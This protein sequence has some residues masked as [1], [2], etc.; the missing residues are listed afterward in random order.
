MNNQPNGVNFAASL[1]LKFGEED[2]I[3]PKYL[4]RKAGR[5]TA[6]HKDLQLG[7]EASR[8]VALVLADAVNHPFL[9]D[10]QVLSVLPE[11]NGQRLCVTVGHY[12]AMPDVTEVEMVEELKRIQGV[13]RCALAQAINRKRMPMLS[14][15]Y[16]GL[17]EQIGQTDP[18]GA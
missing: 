17:I 12:G 8:I 18:G 6:R 14:F 1:C 15:R 7:K 4:A 10:L 16:V 11:H 3:D 2:G 13:L 9:S 5:K